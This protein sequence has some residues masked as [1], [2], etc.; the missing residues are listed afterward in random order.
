MEYNFWKEKTILLIDDSIIEG[1]N[2]KS[3][4][5]NIKRKLPD[6]EVIT[7]IIKWDET[8]WKNNKKL[9]KV[10]KFKYY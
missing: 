4:Y 8:K 7:Y 3:I 1:T 2:I 5:E 9:K 10:I 6:S